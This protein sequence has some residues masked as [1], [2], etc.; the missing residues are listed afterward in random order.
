MKTERFSSVTSLK[1]SYHKEIKFQVKILQLMFTWIALLAKTK[2]TRLPH[3]INGCNFNLFLL[4]TL[5]V[6]NKLYMIKNIKKLALLLLVQ[7]PQ[8]DKINSNR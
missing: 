6:K 2:F 8:K 7:R 3:K 1:T 5:V 4:A